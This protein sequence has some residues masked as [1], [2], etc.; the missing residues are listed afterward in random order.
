MH[1]WRPPLP[2]HLISLHQG[3]SVFGATTQC[4]VSTLYCPSICSLS[5]KDALFLG[6]QRDVLLAPSAA[7]P[8]PLSPPRTLGS[9]RA[10]GFLG[11]TYLYLLALWWNIYQFA[12]FVEFI[13]INLLSLCG[14]ETPICFIGVSGRI[15]LTCVICV[16]TVCVA[17]VGYYDFSIQKQKKT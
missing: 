8:S 7:L 1:F 3:R 12:Y 2:F 13:Y 4:T 14:L 5:A 15:D 6:L 17:R 9:P 11:A 10:L 16:G